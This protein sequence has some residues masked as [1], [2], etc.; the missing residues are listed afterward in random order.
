MSQ[1]S[2]SLLDGADSLLPR[3]GAGEY[4]DGDA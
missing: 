3:S 2:I 1:G 4:S